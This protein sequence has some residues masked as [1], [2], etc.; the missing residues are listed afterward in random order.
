MVYHFQQE[1]GD[2]QLDKEQESSEFIITA[3]VFTKRALNIEAVAITFKNLWQ[4]RSGFRIKDLGNHVVLFIFDK[5]FNTDKI[6]SSETWSFDRHLVV[7]LRYDKYK[8][9]HELYFN[10]VTFWVQ[11]F[12]IWIQ[13]V[14]RKVAEGICSSIGKAC[15]VEGSENDHESEMFLNL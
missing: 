13:F 10:Q 9:V 5:K 2:L 15:G 6:L 14:N 8:P 3:K 4:L 12:N 1:G 7:I 11:L